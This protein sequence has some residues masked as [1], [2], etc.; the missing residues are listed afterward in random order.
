M[1]VLFF[2]SYLIGSIPFAYIMAWIWRKVDIRKL[3]SENVGATNVIKQIG[4]F[5]GVLA[6]V[7]DACKG[8]V[9]VMVGR[10]FGAGWEFAALIMAIVG[11]IWPVWLGFHGGGGLATF[12]GGMLLI[13]KWWVVLMI[14][15]I[16][17][18]AYMTLKKHDQ[19]ALAACYISPIVL[20]LAHSS[21]AHFLFGV[22]AALVIGV[23]RVFSIRKRRSIIVSHIR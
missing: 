7:L 22:G 17:G 5:P 4:I 6:G 10:E 20:G 19:S 8:I 11:H 21:W 13:S 2:E 16:W 9:V 15:G 1:L 18:L 14:I 12:I 3:G 23:R